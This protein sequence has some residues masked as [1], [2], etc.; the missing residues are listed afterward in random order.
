MNIC[1]KSIQG[2]HKNESSEAG[3]CLSYL[4]ENKGT[5]VD[6]EKQVLRSGRA[7]QAEPCRPL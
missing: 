4:R 7:D 2:E 3:A 5:C 1:K 6:R